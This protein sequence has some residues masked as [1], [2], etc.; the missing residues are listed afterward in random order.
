[1][2]ADK[3]EGDFGATAFTFTVT[4]SFDTES[5]VSVDWDVSGSEVD[6]SDFLPLPSLAPFAGLFSLLSNIVGGFFPDFTLFDQLPFGTVS[7][8][9]GQTTKTITVWVLG[10]SLPENDEDFTV[11]LSNPSDGAVIGDGSAVGTIRNDDNMPST[12][13]GPV[14]SFQGAPVVPG[15]F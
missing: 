4:R 12:S 15:Q 6:G 13:S 8:A 7:F 14:L 11:T 2:S 5:A 10:N 1:T 9:A 3:M